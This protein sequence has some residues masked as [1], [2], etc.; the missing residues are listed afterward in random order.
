[1]HG[2]TGVSQWTPL[3]DMYTQPA[4]AAPGRRPGRGA[5]ARGRPRRAGAL[6]G[7]RARLRSEGALPGAAAVGDA[8]S[9][10]RERL[11]RFD[12]QRLPAAVDGA[13][14]APA[15]FDV[16]AVPA[17]SRRQL[18]ERD[19]AHQAR[20]RRAD[21]VVRAVAERQVAVGAAVDDRNGRA[22]RT[23][24]RR[25]WRRRREAAPSRPAGSSMPCSVTGRVVVRQSP[26]TGV[27]RR[28]NSSIAAGMRSGSAASTAARSR[29]APAASP[30]RWRRGSSS[31]RCRRRSRLKQ[32]PS[33]SASLRRSPSISDASSVPMRSSA[34]LAPAR[35]DQ[36]AESTR[37][38][39]AAP[40][41]CS[42]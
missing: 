8:C 42:S 16:D 38:D 9:P 19:A 23:R 2:A 20:Q 27:S 29:D 1:M 31:S 40:R 24:A 18:L 36:V 13:A 15:A 28:R 3:A 7:R 32:K 34:A 6:G 25:D 4:H 35:F 21:A 11:L 41:W 17:E 5:L 33:T 22:R 10:D 12:G 37:T 14:D 39:R 30:C 26:C